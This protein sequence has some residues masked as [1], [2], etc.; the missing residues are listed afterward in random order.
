M[1]TTIFVLALIVML[2]D[3]AGNH[4]ANAG[5]QP[6][7]TQSECETYKAAMTAKLD[8]TDFVAG[9]TISPCTPVELPDATVK[10]KGV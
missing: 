9:Y 8:S 4:T 5:S 7:P 2:T 10:T 1:T 3:A 6:F